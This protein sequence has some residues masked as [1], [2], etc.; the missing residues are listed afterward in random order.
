[1]TPLLYPYLYPKTWTD[2]VI[3]KNAP[4]PFILCVKKMPPPPRPT[5]TFIRRS[6]LPKEQKSTSDTAV[7]L[8]ASK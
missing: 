4:P 6:C 5:H 8:I 2:S 3:K 7:E 1:M